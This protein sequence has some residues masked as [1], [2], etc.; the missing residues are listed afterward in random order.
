MHPA[1]CST[2]SAL[3]RRMDNGALAGEDGH[4]GRSAAR[5]AE[6]EGRRDAGAL[7]L[8]VENCVDAPSSAAISW[9]KPC[10]KTVQAAPLPRRTGSSPR[11]RAAGEDLSTTKGRYRAILGWLSTGF[12][13]GPLVREMEEIPFG[14]T[15]CVAGR[16]NGIAEAPDGLDSRPMNSPRRGRKP[17]VPRPRFELGTPAFSG[18]CSTD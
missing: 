3:E 7:R 11:R 1:A 18:R 17:M 14:R 12:S 15:F 13:T 2:G 4:P 9:G 8:I 10:G 16:R 5:W 6:R